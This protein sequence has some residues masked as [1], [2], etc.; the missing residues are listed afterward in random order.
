[1]QL[2]RGGNICNSKIL[3]ERPK[4]RER[5]GDGLREGEGVKDGPH[6][7]LLISELALPYGWL[8]AFKF[9]C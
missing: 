9:V 8:N 7:K 6:S 5:E 2:R 3:V 1:M 4:G